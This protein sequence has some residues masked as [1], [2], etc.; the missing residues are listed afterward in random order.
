MDLVFAFPGFQDPRRKFVV[1][2]YESRTAKVYNGVAER[3]IE[4]TES[5]GVFRIA[6]LGGWEGK[7]DRLEGL[8]S[9]APDWRMRLPQSQPFVMSRAGSGF[10]AVG[11][12]QHEKLEGLDV[13]MEG[14]LRVRGREIRVVKSSPPN[15]TSLSWREV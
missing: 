2:D 14:V 6:R 7:V 11:E 5:L 10:D 15:T 13:E 3:L 12:L 4:D 1:P 8:A 9:W